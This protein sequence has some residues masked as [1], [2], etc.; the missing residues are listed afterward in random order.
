MLTALIRALDDENGKVR[1]IAVR[2]LENLGRAAK[3]AL[4][5]LDRLA[6]DPDAEIRRS[7][8]SAA[9]RIRDAERQ[10]AIPKR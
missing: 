2:G 3:D 1:S 5:A 6:G 4:P 10:K 8:A 7:A 9:Q